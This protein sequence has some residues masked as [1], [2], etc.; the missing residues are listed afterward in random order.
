MFSAFFKD[1]TITSLYLWGMLIVFLFVILF[2]TLVVY[3]EYSDLDKETATIRKQYLEQQKN[4]IKFDIDRVLK[5]IGHSYETWQDSLNEEKLKAQIINAIEELYGRP[6]GT[7]Y[8]FI[9]DFNGTNLSDP[10][11]L[12]NKGKN[13][14][15]FRDPNGVEVIKELIDVSQKPDGG[16]VNYMWIK[17]GTGVATPKLS[18][19]R[20]FKPW[21]WM[22]G[23]GVYLDEVEKLIAQRKEKLNTL[24]VKYMMD[25]LTLTVI[26]LGIGFAGIAIINNIIRKEINTFSSF[27]KKAAKSHTTIDED[28]IHLR[29][30]KHMV[31]YINDMVNS[32]HKRNEKLLE[33][34]LTLEKRVEQKTEDLREKNR[35]LEKEK[36]FS[37]SLVKAQDSFIKHSIHEINT[38]LAV[39]MMHIDMHKIK[40]GEDKYLSQIEAASKMIAN[41]YDD[42]SYMVKKDRFEYDKKWISFSLFLEER[43]AFFAEIARGNKHR[44]ISKI[45]PEITL[46]FSDIELQRIIDNNLSNAVKY[47]HRNS[48]IE[49]ALERKEEGRTVLSFT[50]HSKPIEDTSLI[51]EPFHQEESVHGGFGLGLEIVRSICEKEGVEV[52]VISDTEIT[53][54]SY[55]F[56]NSTER[57]P[58]EDPLA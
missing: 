53:I 31:R 6:D 19:A 11:H 17:P 25:I 30:F 58:D 55:T 8:V 20:A 12:Q 33:M 4:T 10:I 32:I 9:Y 14:Y 27:F 42:L 45:E 46:C 52:E 13:L 44:I 40:F 2:T 51:F 56:H 7:G 28:Q 57:S 34:N 36:E 5:F 49:V 35:L 3:E 21:K 16:F 18:Y 15:S 1:K 22:V 26:F 39:I 54:F 48:D 24:L 23:T 50:T 41:I 43:I 38:P 37:E 47:A 29:E